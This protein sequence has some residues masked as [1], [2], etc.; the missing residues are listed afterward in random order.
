MK[1]LLMLIL[2][3]LVSFGLAPS[4]TYA[5]VA[6]APPTVT[7]TADLASGQPVGT[8]ITWSAQSSDPFF[9]EFRLAIREPGQTSDRVMFDFRAEDTFSW[10]PIDQGYYLFTVTARN[11]ITH[12]QA[13]AARSFSIT[14]VV[15]D[16]PIVSPTD[17]PLVALYSAPACQPGNQMRVVF[18]PVAGPPYVMTPAKPCRLGK[19]VNIY[20]AGMR[21]A[22]RYV[23]VHELLDAQGNHLSFGPRRTFRSGTPDVPFFSGEVVVPPSDETSL[24]E[25]F[26]LFQPIARVPTPPDLA[27]MTDLAGNVVWYEDTQIT[28]P[29]FSGT[30]ELF[31]PT[32]E[33][34]FLMVFAQD[35]LLGQVLREIDMLGNV[36]RETNIARVR[37]QITPTNPAEFI[38]SFH[39]ETRRL[40]NG[41][42]AVLASV[43]QFHD[44]GNGPVN[45][46]GDYII[47]LDEDFQV[48]WSWNTF[49][50]MDIHREAILGEICEPFAGGCPP[51][52]LDDIA[53]D[54]T[55]GNSIAYSPRDHNLIYSTRHQD[56]IVKMAYEDGAGDG[57]IVWRLGPDGDF[58]TDS[59]DPY[60]WQSHQHDPNFV[61]DS[62]QI[63]VYDNA[64]TRCVLLPAPCNS[65]GIVYELDEANMVAHVRLN[66]DFG[67]FDFAVGSAQPLA[68]GNFHFN[69]GWHGNPAESTSDEYTPDGA[70]AYSFNLDTRAYRSFRLR[71][72]YT[73]AS[74]GTPIEFAR[75][76]RYLALPRER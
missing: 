19:S 57:H 32:G 10:T 68:N 39:H 74:L 58:T 9:T 6:S 17:H 44:L 28:D 50:H 8:T 25:D 53:T 4:N 56:W 64:N 33:G 3:G 67:H 45:I 31:R 76:D 5:S 7:L 72:P 2:S 75:V 49:D 11:P 43:E 23:L 21:A 20:V 1:F 73:D 41:H 46:V 34:T 37:E 48:A 55:H 61:A 26:L 59:T 15:T 71:D 54:W 38:G 18:R 36:V 69:S 27:F 65:R 52:F 14:S 13:S 47:V 30:N 16:S 62:N 29:D 35:G 12:E 63:V 66:V 40:P 60:P 24:S 70:L 22:T 51:L 42:T